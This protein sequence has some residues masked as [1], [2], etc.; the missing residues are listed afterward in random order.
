[1]PAGQALVEFTVCLV[2]LL[3]PCLV[4]V[5][6]FPEITHLQTKTQEAAR[7]AWSAG[8]EPAKIESWVFSKRER[9]K[10]MAFS[11]RS[12]SVYNLL[13][14]AGV[15]GG[16]LEVSVRR[17]FDKPFTHT[18][19]DAEAVG[20]KLNLADI[21]D[22]VPD[23]NVGA[24]YRQPLHFTE[25]KVSYDYGSVV[26]R[27]LVPGEGAGAAV[28]DGIVLESSYPIDVTSD[29][30]SFLFTG[31]VV[32][33]HYLEKLVSLHKGSVIDMFKELFL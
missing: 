12:Q 29:F 3:L 7:L 2:F 20:L 24:G 22:N 31:S 16:G 9:K 21:F 15:D 5:F 28:I 23:I 33:K 26:L 13:P 8:R 19:F 32:V 11:V 27:P 6:R 18:V 4:T 1:M 25:Y 10:E 30:N 17:L 14:S